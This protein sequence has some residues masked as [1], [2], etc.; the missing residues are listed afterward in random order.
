MTAPRTVILPTE[1][2]TSIGPVLTLESLTAPAFRGFFENLGVGGVQISTD[3][4]FLQVN[5]RFI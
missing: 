5:Q 2:R 1:T 4:R 3:G